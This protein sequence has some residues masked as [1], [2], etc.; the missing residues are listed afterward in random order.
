LERF[1]ADVDTMRDDLARLEKR[2]SL[3]ESPNAKG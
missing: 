2:L 3:L 1:L